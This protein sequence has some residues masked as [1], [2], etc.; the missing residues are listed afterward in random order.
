M[1][2][3]KKNIKEKEPVEFT[4]ITLLIGAVVGIIMTASNVYLGL[5]AGMT[6]SASIPAAV[7]AA[8]IFKLFPT[9][10][11]LYKS[12]IVQT[13]A[14]AG[15]SL[16]AGITFTVPALMLVG[17]WKDFAFWPTTIIAISGGLLG[18]IFMIPLRKALISGEN[19]ELTYPEGVACPLYT[20]LIFSYSKRN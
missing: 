8:G 1:P 13:M 5:Y 3:N 11:A 14:S 18:V 4:F 2:S 7:I 15:E 9:R 17:A 12:N 6:V 10:D 20:S 19:K 16:A